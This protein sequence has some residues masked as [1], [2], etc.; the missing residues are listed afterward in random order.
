V[1]QVHEGRI[2]HVMKPVIETLVYHSRKGKSMSFGEKIRLVYENCEVRR[3][4]V[5]R[6][7]DDLG[8]E[9][10]YVSIMSSLN[11]GRD[12]FLGSRVW[13]LSRLPFSS[14]TNCVGQGFHRCKDP[15]AEDL[16]ISS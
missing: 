7:E 6:I 3:Y 13:N 4:K 8:I 2:D 16:L 11:S 12:F 15:V 14:H 10:V 9:R 1:E 5:R